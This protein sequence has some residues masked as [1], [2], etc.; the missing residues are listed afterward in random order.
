M[1]PGLKNKGF[2]LIELMVV[3]LIMSAL[4]IFA[5]EEYKRHIA[6]TRI[7]RARAD[8]E[9]LIK[10][11]RLFNI[12][13]SNSFSVA[14]FSPQALGAFIGTYLEKEPPRDPWGNF[15]LHSAD[16]GV[17]FSCGP[18]G[19][20]QTI[21]VASETDDV[22]GS[23]LPQGFF[24]TRAEYVD[25]NL[26]NAVDISD[27]IDITFSRPAKL[28][29]PL[30]VDF[31]TSNPEKALGSA[32]VRPLESGFKARIEF[33]PPFAPLVR[34]GETRLFPREYIDSVVDL[35][36]YPQRLQRQEGLIIEKR[37]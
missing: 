21:N 19:K 29:D 10:A 20:P 34:P 7:T 33:A 14:V 13:E 26:N 35:S 37:K 32:L 17:V 5:I 8:I 36:P 16:L 1:F 9:E 2:A 25:A 28:N 3:L 11:V 30:A 24:I 18:D 23:Y 15:Y 12:K 22:V 27:Y 4:L 31:E 6:S